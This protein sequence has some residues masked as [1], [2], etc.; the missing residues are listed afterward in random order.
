[1][2][3]MI[4]MP[5]VELKEARERYRVYNFTLQFDTTFM[6]IIENKLYDW[7]HKGCIVSVVGRVMVLW[8]E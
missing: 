3:Y 8:N 7:K 5:F 2:I 4:R 6:V 1:M